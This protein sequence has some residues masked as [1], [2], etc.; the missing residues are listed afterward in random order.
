[1]SEHRA[2]VT[3]RNAGSTLDY[4]TYSRDHEWRCKDGRVQIAASAAPAFK[5]NAATIDPEDA[6]VA[7]LSSCHMLTFLAIAARR[8]LTVEAYADDAVG[9]LEKNAD[10][11][12]AVTRVELRPRVRFAAGVAVS[13]DE[14]AR[15]HHKAHEQCF[16]ANSVRT[17]VT[18]APV[19][20]S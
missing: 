18:C 14:F 7:A 16:I 8:R 6:L 12:L 9:H 5:G 19:I 11:A 3:W 20:E 4:E 2:T 17:E 15:L 1:M 10:G 13:A